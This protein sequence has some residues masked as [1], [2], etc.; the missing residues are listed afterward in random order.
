VGSN[1][2]LARSVVQEKQRIGLPVYILGILLVLGGS[3]F[4]YYVEFAPKSSVAEAP[5]TPEAKA[6]VGNLKLDNVN[7]KATKD[8]FGQMVVEIQ[9][10]IANAGDRTLDSVEIY[11]VFLDPYGQMALR[12]RLPIVSPAMGG[13]KP[14][15]SKPFRL[16]FDQLPDSWDQKMPRMVIASVKFS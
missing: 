5:L 15:E 11:C 12:Q 7:M 10:T 8:Y 14:G 9:G 13:L 1:L 6:Y 3:L 4:V 2:P 16:P